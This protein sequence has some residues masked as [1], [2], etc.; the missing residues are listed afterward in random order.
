LYLPSAVALF[1][2]SSYFA[3]ALRKA[4]E[5][6]YLALKAAGL[7]LWRRVRGAGASLT[8]RPL[9]VPAT[10]YSLA[11]SIVGET[12]HGMRFKL[13][14]VA[15]ISEDNARGAIDSFLDTIRALE[16][17]SLSAADQE[18]LQTYPVIGG[19]VVV[20]FDTVTRQ[21]VAVPFRPADR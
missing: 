9:S 16:E 7:T 15:D 19:Q 4:G 6:H 2:A 3:G 1:I 17:G 5:D 14:L 12:R 13:V 21:I 20:T 18:A 8:M 10:D 11:W